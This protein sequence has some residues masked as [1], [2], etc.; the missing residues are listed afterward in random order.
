MLCSALLCCL[1]SCGRRTEPVP[2]A[3]PGERARTLPY[4]LASL[5]LRSAPPGTAR[6]SNGYYPEWQLRALERALA[7]PHAASS[8]SDTAAEMVIL[9]THYPLLDRGG[10][11]Y[12]SVHRWYRAPFLSVP[13]RRPSVSVPRP[14]VWAVPRRS[15]PSLRRAAFCP[16]S[17]RAALSHTLPSCR[18]SCC[19]LRSP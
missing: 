11:E 19:G 17:Q 15:V 4:L 6:R 8:S 7:P 1:L 16:L 14:S 12:T 5:P 9:A 13:L 3:P 2:L 18:P 10:K